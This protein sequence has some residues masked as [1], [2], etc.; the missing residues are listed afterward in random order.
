MSPSQDALPT[1]MAVKAEAVDERSAVK[2]R[3][4]QRGFL[5]V[6]RLGG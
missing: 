6:A 3:R 4:K 2:E 1:A 5:A